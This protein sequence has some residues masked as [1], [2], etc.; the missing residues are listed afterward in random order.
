MEHTHDCGEPGSTARICDVCGNAVLQ[1]DKTAQCGADQLAPD[2]GL[3]A[4]WIV[5]FLLGVVGGIIAWACLRAARPVE[6]RRVLLC[7]IGWNVV[8]FA[9]LIVLGAIVG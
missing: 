3:G 8:Y 2:G 5:V 9:L 7:G 4:W 1:C 6:A